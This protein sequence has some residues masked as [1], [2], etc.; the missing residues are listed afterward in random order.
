MSKPKIVLWDIEIILNLPE[1]QKNFMEI[2]EYST[3]KAS[4]SSMIS[5]GYMDLEDKKS[6]CINAWDFPK[7]WAKDINDDYEVVKFAGEYL[8]KCDG[9]VTHYGSGFDLPFLNSRLLYHGLPT[10]PNGIPHIDTCKVARK[11]LYIH[12]NRLNTL[13]KFF[14]LDK[15][16]KHSGAEMWVKVSQRNKK[17]CNEMSKYCAQDVMAL[18]GLFLKLRPLIS[19]IPNYNI[20]SE[21]PEDVRSCANCGHRKLQRWGKHVTKTKTYQRYRCPKCGSYS[22]TDAKDSKP[23]SV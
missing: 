7:R 1:I 4:M 6:K 9:M 14:G 18:K 23:R 5:F 13:T 12:R 11:R 16:M 15:K 22:R 3:M 19:N 8:S 21:N 17:A 10:I 2:Y 20:F